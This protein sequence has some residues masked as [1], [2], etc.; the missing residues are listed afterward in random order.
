VSLGLVRSEVFVDLMSE[1]VCSVGLVRS[2]VFVDLMS[3]SVCSVGL[4]D[5][6]STQNDNA[7]KNFL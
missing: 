6:N 2:E 3:E 5:L 1:S 4:I 7:K